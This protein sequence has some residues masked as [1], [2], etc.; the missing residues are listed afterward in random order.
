MCL[1]TPSK[2]K[3]RISTIPTGLAD[4]S[5]YTLH[6]S[7][8]L[9]HSFPLHTTLYAIRHG[10]TI[11]IRRMQTGKHVPAVPRA[12]QV[13][14]A[15]HTHWVHALHR[16]LPSSFTGWAHTSQGHL[17]PCPNQAGVGQKQCLGQGK[18]G[19]LPMTVR[20]KL[21]LHPQG[22]SGMRGVLLCHG[23]QPGWDGHWRDLPQSKN[24]WIKEMG[25][26]LPVRLRDLPAQ[27]LLLCLISMTAST[28]CCS[29]PKLAHSVAK[30]ALLG[31]ERF[32]PCLFASSIYV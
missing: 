9:F 2:P 25:V 31:A 20:A 12:Q 10:W 3:T 21:C 24:F 5:P 4:F 32:L 22:G 15:A 16:A 26:F 17:S 8:L 23:G 6:C 1:N 29:A 14:S 27:A 7:L 11:H 18:V 28:A 30:E 13:P 19:V